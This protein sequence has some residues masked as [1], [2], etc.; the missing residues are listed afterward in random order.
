[1]KPYLLNN[2]DEA[3]E[4]RLKLVEYYSK[5]RGRNVPYAEVLRDLQRDEVRRL[6]LV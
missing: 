6:K 1:M 5:K 4:W 2:D 3:H